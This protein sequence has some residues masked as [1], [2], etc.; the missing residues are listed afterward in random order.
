MTS[1]DVAFV[2]DGRT[3]LFGTAGRLFR[4]PVADEFEWA[5]HERRLDAGDVPPELRERLL[6]HGLQIAAEGRVEGTGPEWTVPLEGGGR[7]DGAP[8]GRRPDRLGRREH[9]RAVLRPLLGTVL[10]RARRRATRGR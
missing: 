1:V 6:A 2:L 9:D 5:A 10:R 4:I 7:V 3:H 8:R